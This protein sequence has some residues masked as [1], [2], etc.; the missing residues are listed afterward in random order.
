LKLV[1][2]ALVVIIS[3]LLVGFISSAVQA[4]GESGS[5]DLS[6]TTPLTISDISVSSIGYYSA[7]FSWKTNGNATSQVFYD[8]KF[9]EDIA[10]YAYHL[11]E[12]LDLILNH[13]MTLTGLRSSTTYHFRVKSVIPDT[14]F[15][16]ISDDYTFTTLKPRGGGGGITPVVV[17]GGVVAD[18]VTTDGVF[19]EEFIAESFDKLCQLTITEGTIGLTEDGKPLSE[20]TMVEMELPPPPPADSHVIGLAYDFGPDGATFDPPV[21]LTMSYDPENLPEGGSEDNLS[22][23]YWDGTKWVILKTMVDTT[24]KTV[25]CQVSHFTIF[26]IIG[27][28]KPAAFTLTLVD[29]S[30]GEVAPG[31]KVNI[32]VSV[33]NTG[34]MAGSHTVVL[35]INGVEEAEKR[36]TVAAGASEIV[37]FTVSR[38]QPGKYTVMAGGL[39]GGFTVVAPPTALTPAAFSLSDLSIRPAEVKPKQPVTITV[40]VA[41]SG[42][43]E[44]S[45]T[46]VQKINGVK[47]AEKS[48]ALGAGR[49]Q[50]V[51]FS[52]TREEA[53][54]YTVTVDGLSGQ[55][56]V[57]PPRPV[58]W[59]LIGGVIGGV[60]VVGLGV[61][62]WK[63]RRRRAA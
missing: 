34:G 33:A 54:S 21:T 48:V 15:I 55:L 23:A 35:E 14:E 63:R 31:E 36:V 11:D 49:S 37:S 58:N 32:T 44:G 7:I 16:A 41:N 18:I 30:P 24:A 40:T 20:I 38:E 4:S 28:A 52:V 22:I 46:V 60:V 50:E 53:G 13:S 3:L 61:F 12:D 43:T 19:T 2:I 17:A 10:D 25:S 56:T 59:P 29:I 42:G 26:A 47:E 5:V 9:H 62:F 39:G 8:T 57:M 1:R 45:Y 51:S 6:T 27:A